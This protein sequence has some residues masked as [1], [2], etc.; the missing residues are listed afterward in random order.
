MHMHSPHILDPSPSFNQR[1]LRPPPRSPPPPPPPPRASPSTRRRC[2]QRRSHQRHK[3]AYITRAASLPSITTSTTPTPTLTSSPIARPAS[4]GAYL[5]ARNVVAS[6]PQSPSEAGNLSRSLNVS[7]PGAQ[8][9]KP[10]SLTPGSNPG[11]ADVIAYVQ[12]ELGLSKRQRAL[13]APTTTSEKEAWCAQNVEK[14]RRG[15]RGRLEQEKTGDEGELKAG[16]GK[17]R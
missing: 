10:S 11:P 12:D 3:Q 4:R 15:R 17:R 2:T 6:L 1:P 16:E 8:N 14:G 13:K 9:A 5:P 7:K